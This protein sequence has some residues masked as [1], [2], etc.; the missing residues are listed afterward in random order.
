MIS[1][2]LAIGIVLLVLGAL[3]GI[4]RFAQRRWSWN[5]EL[6]RKAVHVCMGLVCA[7]FPWLFHQAW[8]V[9]LLAGGAV[10]ALLAVRRLPFFKARFGHVL[11][12]VERESWGEL[13]FPPAVA[14][15]YWLAHGSVLLY[16]VPVIILTLAD[17]TAALVGTRYGFARYETDDG[18][19][20]LEGSSA[21]FIVA[22][23]CT[24]VP[25]W[26]GSGSGRIEVL[27]IASIMGFILVLIEAIAWRGL[28]NLFIPV[29]SYVCLVRLLQF[30]W[31][32]LLVHLTVLMAIIVALACWST[33]TRLTQSA[34]IGAALLLFVTWAAA[35]WR[36]LIAPV[37]TGIGYTLLCQERIKNPHRHT[38]HA[39]ACIGGVAL[40]WIALWQVAANVH[41]VYAY[42]VAYGTNLGMIGLTHFARHTISRSLITAIL[43]GIALSFWLMATPYLIVWRDNPKAIQMAIGALVI[44]STAL[45][46]FAVWQPALAESPQDGDRW[47][48]QGVI[49]AA[50]SALAFSFALYLEP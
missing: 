4:V 25:L 10:L 17:A 50:A 39:I 12:G 38:V 27:L 7:L 3:L 43:K 13:L 46:A 19:K 11:G 16:C 15:V 31:P 26:F 2:A 18:W 14:F 42:G 44:L 32:V 9:A 21:F 29:A 35:D 40:C 41:S 22:F 37:V 45:A 28:D 1:P 49:S 24:A 34:M 6:S 48:R 23:L 36:W 5:P 47:T 8:A 30:S 20:S 33:L